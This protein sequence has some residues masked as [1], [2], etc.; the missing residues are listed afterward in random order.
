L[1]KVDPQKNSIRIGKSSTLLSETEPPLVVVAVYHEYW[2]DSRSAMSFDRVHFV[3]VPVDKA[4]RFKL[5]N[6]ERFMY[7]LWCQGLVIVCLKVDL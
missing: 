2:A 5:E 3:P 7:D 1:T 6:P 4:H